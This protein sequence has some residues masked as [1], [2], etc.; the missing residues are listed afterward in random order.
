MPNFNQIKMK[1]LV[2]LFAF[3]A[4]AVSARCQTYTLAFDTTVYTPLQNDTILSGSNWVGT[5]YQL[6]LPFP[7]RVSNLTLSTIF[8]HTDGEIQRRVTSG[9]STSFRTVMYGFGNC[10]LRQ[11]QNDTSVISYVTEG[12]SPNRIVKVQFRNAGFTGDESHTDKVNFQIWL[13]ESGKRYDLVFGETSPTSMRPMNGAYGPF[14]GLGSQY[15]RG[16]PNA[17]LLGNLDYGLNGMPRKGF[18]YTF[19]R[20]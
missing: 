14:I 20:P 1:T 18:T 16:L 8:I 3:S 9:G 11:K 12:I 13:H 10:G 15:I 19:S 5:N 6:N 17:P 7:M 2:L 4:L